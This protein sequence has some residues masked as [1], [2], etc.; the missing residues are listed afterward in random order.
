[1]TIEFSILLSIISVTA[2][3]MVG[4]TSMRRSSRK[5]TEQEASKMTTIIVKL[6]HIGADIADIKAELA[7][8]KKDMKEDHER[9][10]TVEASAKHAHRRLD[11]L[12]GKEV[13]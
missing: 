8:M 10:V 7:L 13:Q 2:A 9:L 1:M 5:D 3:V 4:L 6:E 11:K 12:E